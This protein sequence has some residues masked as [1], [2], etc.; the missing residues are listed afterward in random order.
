MASHIEGVTPL[1]D[2]LQETERLFIDVWAMT[3][4]GK[5]FFPLSWPQPLIILNFE[6]EGPMASLRTAVSLGV[7][8]QDAEVYIIEPVKEA[9][10]AYPIARTEEQDT[11]IYGWMQQTLQDVVEEYGE[12][13]GTLVFDTMTTFHEI[14]NSSTMMPIRKKR[15]KQNKEVMG[16]DWGV[17]NKAFR[18]VVEGIRSTTN[19]NVVSLEHASRVYNGAQPTKRFE[20]AGPARLDQWV[21]MTGKLVY[22]PA[23]DL[24]PDDPNNWVLEI[25]KSRANI[26]LQGRGLEDPSYERILDAIDGNVETIDV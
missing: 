16:F 12:S 25:G 26:S 10:N 5:S 2:F 24:D 7:L 4:Q 6:P 22:D 17:R 20:S 1:S 3:G 14:L 23:E 18:G 13:G 21:D 8:S 9:L 15:E 11:E 19:L